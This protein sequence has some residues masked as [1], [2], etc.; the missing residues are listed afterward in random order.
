MPRITKPLTNTEVERAKPKDKEYNLSDGQ[1]LNLRIKPTGAKTWTFNYYH[2]TTKKRTNLTVGN[3][4]ELSIAQARQQR[5][6]WRAL[7]AQGIDPQTHKARI[8][9]EKE[10]AEAN[11]FLAIAEKWRAKKRGEI[12]E[13]TLAKYWGSLTLHVFPFIGAYPIAEIVPTLALVPLQRVEERNNIDMANRLCGYINEILNFAVNGGLIPFNPCLKMNKTLKQHKKENNPHIKSEELPAFMEA[14]TNANIQPQTRLLVQFQMLTMTRPNE[15]SEAQW[16]E[17]DLAKK[18]WTIP[19]ERMKAREAHIVPLSSQAIKI[20]EELK[21]ISGRFEYI[22]PKRGNNHEPMSPSSANMA[23]KRMG[24]GGK[25]TAHGLR[26]LAR[27]HLADTNVIY[28]HA[29]A[30]LAHRTGSNVSQ[31]Y[32]HATY[33]KQRKKIMQDWGDFVEQCTKSA[34]NKSQEERGGY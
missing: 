30:C 19:A 21:P 24:Y 23:I 32:N 22:F 5:E 17:I 25:Q 34:S 28:E 20:L 15:A 7:L 6:E 8:A 9:R 14:L 26:G 33:M 2:P 31:S 13:K 4:P 12:T 27:T 16:S 11:T 29:E 10:L 3:Y 1:G 18:L